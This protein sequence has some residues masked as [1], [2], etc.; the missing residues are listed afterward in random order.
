MKYENIPLTELAAL[1]LAAQE[2]SVE[3]IRITADGFSGTMETTHPIETGTIS[4]VFNQVGAN[5]WNIQTD[6]P[7]PFGLRTYRP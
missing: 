1:I 3:I 4:Q 5:E 2:D 7:D 6:P